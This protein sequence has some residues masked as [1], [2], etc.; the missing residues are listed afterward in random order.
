MILP[1]SYTAVLILLIVGMLAWG[2]W[3]NLF[4]A[5]GGKW[6]FELFSFDFAVG[7][8]LAALV[9]GL[10]AG[11]LGFDGFSL[12][13]DLQLA[14]KRHDLWGFTAGVVFNLG[15]MMLL[16]AISIAGMAVAFPACMGCALIVAA[17]WNFAL[18]PGGN[19]A[20][21]FG[22]AAVVAGAIVFD[23]LAFRTW[24]AVRAK[25]AQAEGG[26]GKPRRRRSTSKSVFLSLAGGLLIGSFPPLIQMGRQGED[27]L[28]PYSIGFIF[29]IGVVFST[30][31]FNLFFMNLP[32]QGKAIEIAEYFN[33]KLSRH[34]L[35]VL[36]GAV[37]YIGMIASLVGGRV[38]G[39]ARVGAPLRFALEQGAILIAALCGVFL[40][41][42]YEGGDSAV[43]IR[44]GL[45]F[46][47][48]LAGIGVMT[49][50][51][52]AAR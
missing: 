44:I 3:A 31:V 20:L 39:A 11:S 47:L 14:G 24:S 50:G 23:I 40:W 38:E 1:G 18:N 33:A 45:M 49:A 43:K 46:L 52:V 8:F 15:N 42:E 19:T 25:A 35:G 27:G 9:L 34:G 22:G 26:T 37:W 29:S 6:R 16:G 13:D 12:R 28:G 48:L 10:T 5:A 32:V 30:F 21:L 4:K 51:V 2:A 17:F 7:I 41:R 36:G